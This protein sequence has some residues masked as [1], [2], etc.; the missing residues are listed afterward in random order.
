MTFWTDLVLPIVILVLAIGLVIFV[1]NLVLRAVHL[2][3]TIIR[4]LGFFAIW[5]FVG[6]IIYNWME[7]HII[8]EAHE[9]IK[10]LFMPIQAIYQAF[11]K[12]L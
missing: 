3:I 1:L 11:S 7:A 6:P 4:I 12:L 9:G 5:Y 8:T 10:I 2:D